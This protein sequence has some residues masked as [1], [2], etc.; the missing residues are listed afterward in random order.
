MNNISPD[1]AK[2]IKTAR[3]QA[4]LSQARLAEMLGISKRTLIKYE[5]GENQI[6]AS[7]L[8]KISQF[9]GSDFSRYFNPQVQSSEKIP[10]EEAEVIKTPYF[11]EYRIEASIPAGIAEIQERNGW[12][13]SEILDYD[14]RSHFFLQIDEEYGYSM[15][16][17]LE[18]G[19]LVLVSLTSKI[20]N[21][22]IVVAKWDKTKGAV[23]IF[24]ESAN[25]K[26]IALISYN[27]AVPPVFLER[28]QAQI[29]KVVLIKKMN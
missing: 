12:F 17:L 20:Q 28:H 8:H 5:N 29:F 1:I 9:C 15:M 22:N 25:K 21:G 24:N 18:P 11:Y 7:D 19:D 10:L 27:Q 16:P 23:K 2:S 26:N 13:E 4:G 3:L 6:S 14:P